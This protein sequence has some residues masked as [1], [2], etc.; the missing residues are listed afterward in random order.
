MEGELYILVSDGGSSGSWL[1]VKGELWELSS[2]PE[3]AAVTETQ[4]EELVAVERI[5]KDF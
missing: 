4:L 1:V 3:L 5:T 2:L